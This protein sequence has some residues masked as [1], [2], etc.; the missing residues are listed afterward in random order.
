[1]ANVY[2]TQGAVEQAVGSLIKAKDYFEKALA[3]SKELG[4]RRLEAEGCLTLGHF[5]CMQAEYVRAEENIKK[6]LALSKEIGYIDG[7]FSSLKM[8][9]QLRMKG[10]KIQEAISYLFSCIGK[11]EKMRDSL[12]DHDQFKIAFSDCNIL[13]YMRLSFLLCEIGNPTEALYVSE[14]SKARALADLMSARYSVENQISANPGT[15]AGLEGIVAKQCNGTCLYISYFSDKIYL[16]ILKIGGVKH[17]QEIKGNVVIAQEGLSQHLREFFD[18]RSFG[19]LPGSFAKT[20][21]YMVS[22]KHATKTATRI[23]ELERKVKL[24]KDPK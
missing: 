1:M 9:A 14:L 22:G 7:Q 3:I 12:S 24:M 23:R 15:W 11:C 21:L 16:W 5:F 2:I 8:M 20:D 6:G 13:S 10:G 4:N 17:F 19:I 18:F